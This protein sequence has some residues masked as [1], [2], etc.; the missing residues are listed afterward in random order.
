M[1]TTKRSKSSQINCLKE[2]RC[3]ICLKIRKTQTRDKTEQE[4]A[5]IVC[6]DYSGS[7]N[8]VS[9]IMSI[10]KAIRAQIDAEKDKN[11]QRRVVLVFFDDVVEVNGGGNSSK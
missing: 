5:L 11:P 7:M 10:T 6:I 9:R 4:T 2:T 1:A 8:C 3:S